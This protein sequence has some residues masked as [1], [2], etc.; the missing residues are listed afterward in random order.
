MSKTILKTD[1]MDFDLMI[2]SMYSQINSRQNHMEKFI[3]MDIEDYLK[4]DLTKSFESEW[5]FQK[6]SRLNL[7]ICSFLSMYKNI[8]KFKKKLKDLSFDLV[9]H[10]NEWLRC[11]KNED[12]EFVDGTSKFMKLVKKRMKALNFDKRV[13]DN[14]SLDSGV[15]A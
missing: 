4:S 2:R 7:A 15:S 6:A 8:E 14:L 9:K 13:N 12:G 11:E 5:I 10:N 3:D 1:D